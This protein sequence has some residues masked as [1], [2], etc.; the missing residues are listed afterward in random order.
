MGQ[1]DVLKFMGQNK[2]WLENSQIAKALKISSES[3]RSSLT[4]LWEQKL[5]LRKRKIVQNMWK[6]LWKIK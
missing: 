4:K 3:S 2:R 1:G 5:I 6:Y